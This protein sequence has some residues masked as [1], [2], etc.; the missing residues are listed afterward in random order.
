MP[1]WLWAGARPSREHQSSM[2]PARVVHGAVT[3]HLA[4]AYMSQYLDIFLHGILDI[5][6]STG[7][8]T[9]IDVYYLRLR[10]IK[11][12]QIKF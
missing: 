3:R 2:Q 1:D 12:P 10:S 9:I 7:L 6:E 11:R 5:R 4:H 8:S